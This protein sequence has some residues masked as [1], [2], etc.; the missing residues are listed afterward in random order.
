VLFGEAIVAN[1][2][3]FGAGDSD[4]DGAVL[5]DL[6]HEVLVEAGLEFADFAT[7]DAGDMNVVA[8]T[9]GFVVVTITAKVEEVQFVDE[10]FLFEQV[11]GAVD[12][13]EV[14]FGID[15]LRAIEDLVDVEVLLG[16]IHDLE[17]DAALAGETNAALAK[18]LLQMARRGGGVD[19]FAGRDAMGGSGHGGVLYRV[20]WHG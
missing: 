8:R 14:N 1:A 20:G 18:R 2:A 4:L 5:G 10:T 9:M 11:D 17:N 15:F 3:Y 12:R 6:L 13:D 19:A 16:G 7:A